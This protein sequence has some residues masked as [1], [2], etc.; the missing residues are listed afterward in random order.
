VI[1]THLIAFSDFIP[2]DVSLLLAGQTYVVGA[3]GYPWV[4]VNNYGSSLLVELYIVHPLKC[5]ETLTFNIALTDVLLR[6]WVGR[7]YEATW[8]NRR[9]N[10]NST[11]YRAYSVLAATR[12]AKV[13]RQLP[14]VVLNTVILTSTP[15]VRPV[16][17]PAAV[18]GDWARSN[19]R[20]HQQC[21]RECNFVQ[22]H[23]I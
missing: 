7:I 12:V 8:A 23:L 18:V 19:D 21:S 22:I 16:I 15:E 4:M 3:F 17:D 13:P 5:T 9:I 1:L 10:L 11:L 2:N 14:P 6:R 20:C